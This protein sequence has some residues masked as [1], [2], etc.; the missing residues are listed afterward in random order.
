M[1]P[2]IDLIGLVVS[3]MAASLAFYRRLG[4]D[5]PAGADAEP[6]V[7]ASLPGGLRIA[8]DTVDTIRSF[9]PDWTPPQGGHRI[10]LAFAC[11]DP[12]DVDRTYA[13]LLAAGCTGHLKPWNAFWGMRYAAVLD[14]DGNSVDLFAPLPTD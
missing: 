6:H 7:E 9:D 4:L 11:D 12:A 1:P 14:P 2:R 13:E 8:W 10:G 5:I 3:D